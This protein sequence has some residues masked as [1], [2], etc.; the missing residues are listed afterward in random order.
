MSINIRRC[1]EGHVWP[2]SNGKF[3]SISEMNGTHLKNAYLK[4]LRL[5]GDRIEL[6]GMLFMELLDRGIIDVPH[7]HH[8][9]MMRYVEWACIEAEPWRRIMWKRVGKTGWQSCNSMPSWLPG[10]LYRETLD[11]FEEWFRAQDGIIS[12]KEAYEAGCNSK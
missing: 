12:L 7:I 3:Y 11:P 2:G 5:G 1:L 9:M 4:S 8:K 6:L 10:H